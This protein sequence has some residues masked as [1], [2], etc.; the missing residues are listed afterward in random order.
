MKT[1]IVEW[2]MRRR[3]AASADSSASG[4]RGRSRRTART[5]RRRRPPR[6]RAATPPGVSTISSAAA[7]SAHQNAY[8]CVT[9]RRRGMSRASIDSTPLSARMRR[10][11]T[12]HD[13]LGRPAPPEQVCGLLHQPGLAEVLLGDLGRVLLVEV[14]AR[15]ELLHRVVGQR[16]LD[17]VDDLRQ[18]RR[19]PCRPSRSSSAA[20]GCRAGTCPCRPRAGL[21]C[22][23]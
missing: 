22:C 12:S 3:T 21:P 14:D 20:S 17:L 2:S 13:L 15:V 19:R 16:L 5:G 9:P 6:P 8:A 1:K 4:G 10:R 11:R 7:T 23:A 18:V